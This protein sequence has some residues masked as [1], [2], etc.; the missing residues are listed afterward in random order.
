MNKYINNFINSTGIVLILVALIGAMQS[1]ILWLDKLSNGLIVSMMVG[2]VVLILLI[3]FA[4][5]VS[6][7]KF[8]LLSDYTKNI[9]F[10][11]FSYFV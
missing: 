3:A 1:R 5:K 8:F 9:Y 4:K 2:V 11:D 10:G 7:R 6:F